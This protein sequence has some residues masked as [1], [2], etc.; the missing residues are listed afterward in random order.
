[1]QFLL[2]WVIFSTWFTDKVMH[3]FLDT[4]INFYILQL[5]MIMEIKQ[6]FIRFKIC[7]IKVHLYFWKIP[8]IYFFILAVESSV[9]FKMF[10][11]CFDVEIF[12]LL[13]HLNLW[14]QY[15]LDLYFSFFVINYF[16]MLGQ[17]NLNFSFLI[18]ILKNFRWNFV[19]FIWS[20]IKMN[21]YFN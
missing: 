12:S 6:H 5:L 8:N 4:F 21:F 16:Y 1:M 10:R 13:L 17:T 15:R 9:N 2:L 11:I 20:F 18:L 19:N 3:N 14:D 7:L